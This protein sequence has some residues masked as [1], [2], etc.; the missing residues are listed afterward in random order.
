MR[1][2]RGWQS[3]SGLLFV[4]LSVLSIYILS[5]DLEEPTSETTGDEDDSSHNTGEYDAA[6]VT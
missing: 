5:A 6:A 3:L 1:G 2:G 4:C